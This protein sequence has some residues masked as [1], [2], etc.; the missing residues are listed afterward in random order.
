M[1]ITSNLSVASL[2]LGVV[3]YS[4]M[5][6]VAQS[7]E[8]VN[9]KDFLFTELAPSSTA[10]E[11]SYTSICKQWQKK[12]KTV[13]GTDLIY[14]SCGSP[15]RHKKTKRKP[16][17][18]T[19]CVDWNKKTGACIAKQHMKTGY[20]NVTLGHVVYSIG[21][22]FVNLEEYNIIEESIIGKTDEQYIHACN[23]FKENANRQFGDRLIYV[24]CLGDGLE[25]GDINKS[26]GL[27]Y[28]N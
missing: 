17:Y 13:F 14:S 27:I 23:S 18:E 11:E 20:K 10:A 16:I 15:L 1:S 24:T 12:L 21:K 7:A 4:F 8:Q 25:E 3:L 5:P 22:A 26:T 19:I 28:Y 9:I 6:G 2:I